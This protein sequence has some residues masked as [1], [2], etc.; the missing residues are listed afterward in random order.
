MFFLSSLLLLIFVA[1]S[2]SSNIATDNDN[3]V[4]LLVT[5][6][7]FSFAGACKAIA[8]FDASYA[9]YHSK[10][11]ALTLEG[12]ASSSWILEE[13]FSELNLPS[14][15]FELSSIYTEKLLEISVSR[16]KELRPDLH[17]SS[18]SAPKKNDCYVCSPPGDGGRLCTTIG[19]TD[20][21]HNEITISQL[22][23][24]E[25]HV[26]RMNLTQCEDEALRS[27]LGR[28]AS[29]RLDRLTSFDEMIG[30]Y[31]DA[32]TGAYFSASSQ[33]H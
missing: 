7:E 30:G 29:L 26:P 24:R 16:L 6:Y 17:F 19:C 32:F 5:C 15:T 22:E 9:K 2:I 13:H 1:S 11:L 4:D 10:W 25:T 12:S 31:A 23:P 27:R 33:E 3:S 8:E 18:N 20:S 14:L 21:W 28:N